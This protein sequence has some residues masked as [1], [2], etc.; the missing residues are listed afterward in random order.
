[1]DTEAGYDHAEDMPISGRSVRV[2]Q[3]YDEV[4]ARDLSVIESKLNK[5]DGSLRVLSEQLGELFDRLKP[6]L[7]PSFPSENGMTKE[8]QDKAS[9]SALADQ[10]DHFYE[11][12]E[13]MQ[14]EVRDNIHRLEI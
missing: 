13:R 8:D 5:M 1:M 9:Q 10:L 14:V 12:I 6:V 7:M 2:R 4:R 11:V 3:G